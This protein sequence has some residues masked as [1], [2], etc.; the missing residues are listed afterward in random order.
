MRYFNMSY[1]LCKEWK[2]FLKWKYTILVCYTWPDGSW[3]YLH[4]VFNRKVLSFRDFYKLTRFNITRDEVI[5]IWKSWVSSFVTNDKEFFYMTFDKEYEHG[6]I[7]HL[8]VRK[9]VV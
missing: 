8:P 9:D 7:T 4:S 3:V 1:D 2:G 6:N 5:R